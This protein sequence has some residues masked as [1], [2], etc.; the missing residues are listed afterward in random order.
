MLHGTLT[1]K[2][3]DNAGST[4]AAYQVM[5]EDLSGNTFTGSMDHHDLRELL[6]RKMPLNVAADALD[7]AFDRLG[8]DGYIE[9]TDIE[10]DENVLSGVGLTYLPVAG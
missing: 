8:R 1:V 10:S 9:F 6:Y 5:Y 7:A 2:R 4:A 3:I